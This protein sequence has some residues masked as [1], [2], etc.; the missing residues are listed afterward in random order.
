ME[1]VSAICLVAVIYYSIK[2]SLK[3]VQ[4]K[5]LCFHASSLASAFL[6]LAILH[7]ADKNLFS[8]IVCILA[9]K[10]SFHA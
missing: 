5:V 6:I 10:L 3:I 4:E 8:D 7:V 2:G 9:G 1:I